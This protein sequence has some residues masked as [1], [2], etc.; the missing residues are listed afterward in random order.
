MTWLEKI[1]DEFREEFNRELGEKTAQSVWVMFFIA[2]CVYPPGAI[3]DWLVVPEHFF[4]M[5]MVRVGTLVTHSVFGAALYIARKRGSAVK[6][7]RVFAW[8]FIVLNCAILDAMNLIVGGPE[9]VYYAG[10]I[11]LLIGLM[12]A[13]PWGL[14]E[15]SIAVVFVIL[16]Y[17][18]VMALFDPQTD[19]TLVFSANYFF[20]SS[21]FIGLFWSFFGHSLRIKEFV[22]RKQVEQEKARSE[23][24]LLNILPEEVANEL[25]ANGKV[26]ARYIDSCSILFTDFVGFTRMA[27]RI[28]PNELVQALDKA[29]SRFDG[30]VTKYGLEKLKTIGD[31]Y[32]CAGGV[33]DKQPDHLVRCIMAGLEMHHILETGGLSSA[34]QAPWR[35]R[36]GIHQGPVVAGVIG[37][38]KFAFDLWGD[39]VNTASRLEASGQPRSIN[40]STAVYKQVEE[41]FE[42]VDR[43]FVPVK[44]KGPIGMT[45]LTRLRSRYSG[46]PSGWVPN[47]EFNQR[48]ARW[49]PGL[50]RSTTSMELPGMNWISGAD[51]GK[52]GLKSLRVLSELTPE[53]REILIKV[54]RP[55]TY[56]TGQVLIEQGQSLSVFYLI[57]QGRVAVRISRRRVS[58]EVGILGSGE[59]AGEL[60]FVSWEPASATVVALEEVVALRFD[61]EWMDTIISEHPQTGARLFHSLALVLA[62]RVRETNARLFAWGE[63]AMER[64]EGALQHQMSSPEIPSQ[65]QAA[66]EH[67]GQQM[68]A[69]HKLAKIGDA[70][71]QEQVNG[72]CEAML[73]VV[74]RHA[75]TGENTRGDFDRGICAHILR[76]TFTYF[77]RSSTMER[78]YAKPLEAPMDYVS[79]ERIYRRQ[80]TGHGPLGPYMDAWFLQH[81]L[82][83]AVQHC[84][85]SAATMVKQVHAQRR[86]TE[87]DPFRLTVLL[88][89]AAPELFDALKQLDD[90]ETLALTC[91][92]GE[93]AALSALGQ[94]AAREGLADRFTFVCESLLDGGAGHTRINLPPQDLICLPVM[95]WAG[96]DSEVVSLMDEALESLKPGGTFMIGAVSLPPAGRFVV[97]GL[98]EWK[99]MCWTAEQLR[100]MIAQSA[101]STEEIALEAGPDALCSVATLRRRAK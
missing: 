40:L 56:S 88:S 31:A 70:R 60:S 57:L 46:D 3:L 66:L 95:T 94:A 4:A 85:T 14:K 68:Q 53:D 64:D 49:S 29:F 72:A 79:S 101:F 8:I 36:I 16:Q 90:P 83:R 100:A 73:E 44:G 21:I 75:Y 54:A 13:L 48:R 30:V 34:D 17:D 22:L 5:S 47:E 84:M 86:L 78:I 32:M 50:R 82:A 28:P 74:V 6:Y 92:D 69:M 11:M 1:P 76:E 51:V 97:E 91:V 80:P 24:L 98:L 55:V 26:Q 59:I 89:G 45:R 27:G 35:M 96:S 33:L 41:F 52:E 67:F 62:Q 2:F 10:I 87:D 99:V 37:Q 23:G 19:L 93:L 12:V 39:T 61:L 65:L 18:L 9:T 81:Q 7:N 58:I 42:G 71:V 15:M 63:G 38:K 77:M 25:K 43:G 20:F